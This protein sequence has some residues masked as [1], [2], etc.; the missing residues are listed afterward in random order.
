[1]FTIPALS[2]AAG[3]MVIAQ[4]TVKSPETAHLYESFDAQDWAKAFVSIAKANPSVP[5][6]E[7]TMVT[8]F[9]SALMR[10]YDEHASEVEAQARIAGKSVHEHLSQIELRGR[11]AQGWC[12][13]KNSHKVMDGDLAEAIVERL[14]DA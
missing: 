2:I 12:S 11:V 5:F 4:N 8:W 3:T 13:E 6:D 10:G 7:E 1:M 14:M 9:A